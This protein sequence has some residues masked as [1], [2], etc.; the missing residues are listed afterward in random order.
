MIPDLINILICKIADSLHEPCNCSPSSSWNPPPP[1]HLQKKRPICAYSIK[2]IV[3]MLNLS[4][5]SG[6]LFWGPSVDHSY[7][8]LLQTALLH[9]VSA[10]KS[11]SVKSGILFWGP[12]VD[13]SCK[14]LLQTALRH[15]ASAKKE[16]L[17]VRSNNV[18][19]KNQ[20]FI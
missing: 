14:P 9:Y 8:P 4:M 16:K 2:G 19:E 11:L 17:Y 5:K 20:W 18:I 13:H 7:K 3:Y 10:K 6:I 15:Y 1:P 12:F